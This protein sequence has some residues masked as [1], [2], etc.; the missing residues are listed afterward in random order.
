MSLPGPSREIEAP[1]PIIEPVKVPDGP[2]PV[3]P[4]R[5]P[6]EAPPEPVEPEKVP[7]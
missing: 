4:L 1:E 3:E 2:A 6:V 5:E 7:A